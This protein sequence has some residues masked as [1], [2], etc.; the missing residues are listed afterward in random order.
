MGHKETLRS[1]GRAVISPVRR[2][3]EWQERLAEEFRADSRRLRD[4]VKAQYVGFMVEREKVIFD[5]LCE[6]NS[7]L[8]PKIKE[9]FTEETRRDHNAFLDGQLREIVEAGESLHKGSTLRFRDREGE[10]RN[11]ILGLEAGLSYWEAQ[12]QQ[13]DLP[14]NVI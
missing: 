7:V 3:Y 5:T 4:H 13:P 9:F 12:L 11:R 10:R 2:L 6:S 8:P 14:V 1:V